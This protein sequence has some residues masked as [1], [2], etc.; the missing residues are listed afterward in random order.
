MTG[1]DQEIIIIGWRARLD[2]QPTHKLREKEAPCG[3]KYKLT[4]VCILTG[5]IS[6]PFPIRF[7]LEHFEK[8]K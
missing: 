6:M 4:N 7:Y 2:T 3:V 1:A 5:F 8:G